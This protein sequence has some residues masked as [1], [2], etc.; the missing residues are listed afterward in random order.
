MLRD[1]K[2]FFL[3]EVAEIIGVNHFL[4]SFVQVCLSQL[5]QP[6]PNLSHVVI[7]KL[8]RQISK[9]TVMDMV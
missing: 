8:N 7:P 2:G 9:R 4:L 3:N 5:L 1:L 6:P